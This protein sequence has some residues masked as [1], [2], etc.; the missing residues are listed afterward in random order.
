MPR[1][2]RLHHRRRQGCFDASVVN[3]RASFAADL[4]RAL[5]VRL[6]AQ[7][8]R[9]SGGSISD[10]WRYE[11]DRGPIFV[12]VVA[13]AAKHMLVAE[14]AGLKELADAAAVAVPRVLATGSS[15]AHAWLALE[16]IDFG[17]S[18]QSAQRLLGEALARQ[19]RV[20]QA[21]FGWDR[22]NTIGSMPQVN[23]WGED[24]V[25][26][27]RERRLGFQLDL[28]RARGASA[29]QVDRGRRLCEGLGAFFATYRPAASLLHGDLWGGNW[30]TTR[31]GVPLIFDPAVY[32]GDREADVAMTRLF[33]GFSGEFYAAYESA[34]PLDEGAPLRTDLY[35]LY[36]VLNHYN[37]FGGGYL[38]QAQTMIDRLLAEIGH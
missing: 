5:G 34:W 4:E 11:T 16:W 6:H 14:A 9:V 8:R 23:T 1:G 37:L 15:E 19:H 32:Y 12:K 36:H 7:A 13:L 28:A 3:E 22:D 35:N 31:E 33:G 24:W 21:R 17:E 30:G 2:A 26:F 25:A 18:S 29:R 20:R 27:L 38:S 10:A